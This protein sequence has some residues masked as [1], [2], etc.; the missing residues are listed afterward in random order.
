P[1]TTLF[2]SLVIISCWSL[3]IQCELVLCSRI[4]AEVMPVS[5]LNSQFFLCLSF[6]HTFLD[7]MVDTWSVSD[8]QGWS[9]IS[10]CF[11]N[12]FNS[13]IEVSTHSDLC[14]VYI[15][16]AHSNGS[17]IFLLSLFTACS[18]LCNSTCRC[19][20]RRLSTCIGINYCIEYHYVRS[21]EHTS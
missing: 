7:T 9:R 6:A 21:E 16:I 15:T 3:G 1:Y 19:R 13:L 2:R 14:Y 12:S 11:C 10:F 17:H 20:F 18:E 8:D 4:E 5:T